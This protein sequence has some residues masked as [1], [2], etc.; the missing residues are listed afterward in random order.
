MNCVGNSGVFFFFHDGSFLE[1]KNENEVEPR[2]PESADCT[3]IYVT[4]MW[5]ADANPGVGK[6]SDQWD[7][8]G[9]EQQPTHRRKTKY[10]ISCRKILFYLS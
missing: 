3:I 8:M 7:S 6:L 4:L 5:L 10:N 2:W 1:S 9:L